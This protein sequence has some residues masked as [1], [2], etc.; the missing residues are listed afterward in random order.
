MSLSR[1]YRLSLRAYP[2]AYRAAFGDDLAAAIEEN[3]DGEARTSLTECVSLVRS[4]LQRRLAF[5]KTDFSATSY[6]LL[7]TAELGGALW[8]LAVALFWVVDWWGAWSFQ[9]MP[10]F[11]S[12]SFAF[13]TTGYQHDWLGLIGFGLSMLVLIALL[14]S[15]A[16]QSWRRVGLKSVGDDDRAWSRLAVAV[17]LAQPVLLFAA[18]TAIGAW[19]GRSDLSGLQGSG[20]P[21]AR[22]LMSSGRADLIGACLLLALLAGGST[23]WWQRRHVVRAT[24]V[25]ALLA[26][27]VLLPSIGFVAAGGTFG[28]APLGPWWVPNIAFSNRGVGIYTGFTKVIAQPSGATIPVAVQCGSPDAC[29]LWTAPDPIAGSLGTLVTIHGR[30]ATFVT[31]GESLVPM[32]PSLESLVDCPSSSTCFAGAGNA[33]MP[34]E[35]STNGGRSWTVLRFPFQRRPELVRPALACTSATH[36]IM[37]TVEGLATTEDGGDTWVAKIDFGS[38]PSPRVPN[39]VQSSVALLGASC[40]NALD[41]YVGVTAQSSGGGRAASSTWL[42]SSTDGGLEWRRQL[43]RALSFSDNPAVPVALGYGCYGPG[44][45]YDLPPTFG[46]GCYGPSGCYFYVPGRGLVFTANGGATV[47]SR[48]VSD[49]IGGGTIE[50][51][52]ST[53]CWATSGPVGQPIESRLWRSTNGGISWEPTTALP[54]GLHFGALVYRLGTPALT[55]V[56]LACPTALSCIAIASRTGAGVTRPNVIVSTTDGGRSWSVVDLPLLP[57]RERPRLPS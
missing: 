5:A 4:G 33:Q 48:P 39:E 13:D 43:V 45:C 35:R 46:F 2:S 21:G 56:D 40:V 7:L 55:S 17:L 32:V 20:G 36:C 47:T 14:G 49:G 53:V 52:S 16:R 6:A 9:Q 26:A 44:H 51:V 30:R 1:A 3:H 15:A 23:I 57:A 31:S 41:C 50:C 29:Y 8:L 37:A 19:L 22:D 12:S 28:A 10:G 38:L 27:V 11:L 18:A 34:F 54:D 42:L 25:I 24:A